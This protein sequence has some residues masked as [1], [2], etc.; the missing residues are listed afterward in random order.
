MYM[1]LLRLSFKQA[2]LEQNSLQ[3]YY[4]NNRIDQFTYNYVVILICFQ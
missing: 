3:T 4:G 1:Y 2:T